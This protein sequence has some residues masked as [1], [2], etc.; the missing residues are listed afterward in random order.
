MEKNPYKSTSLSGSIEDLVKL[1]EDDRT[2][3]EASQREAA[4][5]FDKLEDMP[6]FVYNE[7]P[8]QV[9][10]PLEHARYC[11]RSCKWCYG[12]GYVIQTIPRRHYQICN[13]VHRGYTR[14]RL[15]FDRETLA[16][17]KAGTTEQTARQALLLTY[18]F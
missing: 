10:L 8:D 1:K 13:C 4:L 7:A 9:G 15:R 2:A 5:Y 18:G 6:P 3:F 14:M 12:R 16:L 11:K 17:M